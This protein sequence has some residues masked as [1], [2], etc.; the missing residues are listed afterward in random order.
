MKY[1]ITFLQEEITKKIVQQPDYKKPIDKNSTRYKL[2]QSIVK[3][4]S[5]IEKMV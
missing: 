3:D 5:I 1:N 4:E 2:L